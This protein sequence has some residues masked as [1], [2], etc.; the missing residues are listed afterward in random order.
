MKLAKLEAQLEEKGKHKSLE[1]KLDRITSGQPA[2]HLTEQLKESFKKLKEQQEA[3]S[4]KAEALKE[5]LQEA[6]DEVLRAGKGY[7]ARKAP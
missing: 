7:P 1:E 5:K 2:R 4:K 6:K 3:S